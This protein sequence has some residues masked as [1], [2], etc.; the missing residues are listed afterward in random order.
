ME[1]CD[2]GIE[3]WSRGT[4]LLTPLL[5]SQY[6]LMQEKTVLVVGAGGHSKKF[7][8]GAAKKYKLKVNVYMGNELVKVNTSQQLFSYFRSAFYCT[9]KSD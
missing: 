5:R 6:Y 7:I 8:W 4:L 2:S 3:G 1:G 9:A